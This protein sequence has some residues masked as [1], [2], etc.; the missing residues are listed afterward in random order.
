MPYS[1]LGQSLTVSNL[2]SSKRPQKIIWINGGLNLRPQ[3]YQPGAL[4][5]ELCEH[6]EMDGSYKSNIALFNKIP[7]PGDIGSTPSL[8][9]LF[10]FY[11]D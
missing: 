1:T 2:K 6:V 10:C 9:N 3:D 5:T 4:L 7:I 11:I 8:S